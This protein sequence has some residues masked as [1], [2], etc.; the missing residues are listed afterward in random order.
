MLHCARLFFSERTR[1]IPPKGMSRMIRRTCGALRVYAR[2]DLPPAGVWAEDH[3]RFLMDEA[4]ALERDSRRWPRLPEENGAPRLRRAA[5]RIAEAG[6][7]SAPLILLLMREENEKQAWTEAELALMRPAL[8]CALMEEI[9]AALTDLSREAAAYVRAGEQARAFAARPDGALPRDRAERARLIRRMEEME[10]GDALRRADEA[11]R[12]Q[13][14]TAEEISREERERAV[15]AGERLGKRIDALRRLTRLPFDRMAER[16]S[17]AGR[18]L[19]VQDTYRRMD[20][21]SRALYRRAAARIGRRLNTAESAVAR[22]AVALCRD[23]EGHEAEAGYY[24]LERPDLIAEYLMK[25]PASGLRQR[26]RTALFLLPLYGTAALSLAAGILFGAPFF[27]WPLIPLCA[28]EI[29][30]TLYFPLLRRLFPARQLPRIRVKKLTAETRTLVAVPALLTSRRQA[31]RLARHL[32]VLRCANPDDQLHFLLLADFADHDAEEAPQD[33]EIVRAARTAVGELNRRYGGGFYYLHRART[34]NGEQYTGRERKRGALEALNGLLTEGRCADDFAYASADPKA[35]RDRYAF[36]ITLDADTFLPAGAPQ[37]LVGAMLHPLQRGRIGVIQPRM[38]TAP[39]TVRTRTQKLLG[40]RGGTDLYHLA[41]QDLYQDVFGRGSFVGKGIYAPRLWTERLAGRLPVGRLLSHDLI[42]GEIAVSALAEDIVLWDGH[43]SRLA[44][45]EKRLHRWTRGDW[46]LMPFL[47]DRRLPLLSRHK[48]WDNLR[49]SLVPGARAGLMMIGAALGLPALILLGLPWPLHGMGL[50]LLLLPGKA[51]TC[52][53]A[54]ARALYRQLVSHR[55]LLS[56]V[57]AAQGEGSLFPSLIS[58]LSPVVSGGALAF[59]SLSG[60]PFWLGVLLGGAW[61][62]S[63]LLIPWLDGEADRPRPLTNA[64]E[65]G[66]R[67]LARDTWRFFADTVSAR[68]LF[69]PPDNVQTDPEKGPALRTSPTNVGL[70]LLSCCA[71]RELGLISAGEAARRVSDTVRTLEGLETW[72]GHFF[73]WYGL[74]DG[75]PLQPRFVSTVDSGNL[76]GC[77]TACAQL[78]RE[79]MREMTDEERTLP[80]RLDALARRMDFACLYDA[81]ARLFRVGADARTGRLADACYDMLASEARLASYFAVMT[82]QAPRKHWAALGRAVV[83]AGGGPALLS[84]GGTMFEYLMPALLLPLT[85]GTLLG[86]GCR[87][88]MKAQIAFSRPFGISESGYYAFDAEMNY[89]YRAFGVPALALNAET[90]GRAAAPYASLLALPFAPRAVTDNIRRMERLGWR[91]ETGF[92]EAADR[93]EGAA[94]P[95]RIVKS[96]MAHHQGMILCALCNALCGQALVRAFMTPPEAQACADLLWEKA[97]GAARRR[98]PGLPPRREEKPNDSLWRPARSGLPVDTH[99]LSGGGTAWLVSAQ[100]QGYLI[101][102]GMMITRFLEEAGS[103]TGWQT[104]LRDGRTGAV[105]RPAVRGEAEFGPGCVRFQ[106]RWRGWHVRERL[107]VDPLTGMAVRAVR[108]RNEEKT[109]REAEIVS[110]LEIAQ[111]PRPADAAHPNFRDLSVRVSPWGGR[112]LFSRRLPRDPADETPL[113]GHTLLGD[114]ASLCRQGDRQLFLGREGDYALPEQ[115]TGDAE[116]YVLRTGDVTAPCLCLRAG[117]RMAAGEEITLYF[118]VC[119][120]ENEEALERLRLT[121]EGLRNVFSLADTHA[122]MALRRLHMDGRML[123]MY[124]QAL[125]A[126]V[127][128]G[129]PHQCEAPYPREGRSALWRLSASGEGI[130]VTVN[131]AEGPDRALIGH[132]LRWRR[133]LGE[134]GIGCELIFLCPPEE[135]YLTPC[136][137]AAALLTAASGVRE[138]VRIAQASENEARAAESLARLT[139]R[140]GL[141]LSEQLRALR[142][143]TE[144][145]ED[146]RPS[147]P[148]PAAPPELT[149]YNGLGGFTADGSYWIGRPAPVPWH[150]LLCGAAFG[151][152]VCETGILHSWCGNSRLM[153]MT[154]L[155]PDPYRAL[156]AEE[157]FLKDEGGAVWPLARCAALHEMGV[158]LYRNRAGGVEAAVD[159]FSH[160]DR[161]FGV[162]SVTLKSEEERTVALAYLVRFSM[163][164]NGGDTRCRAEAGMA[165]ARGDMRG[166]AWAAMEEG[167]AASLSAAAAFGL[168]GERT[169]RALLRPARGP[170]SAALL[171]RQVTL[172]ARK[173][174]RVTLALGWAEEEE[175]ARADFA[176]LTEAGPAPALREVREAWGRRL[177]ALTLYAGVPALERAVNRWLPYQTWTARLLARMGP[178]QQGGAYGFRDQL[179]DLLPLLYT[180]PAFAR[181]HI[182]L[183]AAHQFPEGDVQHW[184]HPPRRG[185]RTRISDDRIFLPYMT[186]QYVRVTGDESILREQTPYLL[187]PPLSP[188]ERERY[189]EPEE[190]P[191]TEPLLTHCMR[192]LDAAE[193]G[194]HGMPRMGSGDWND[195]MDRVG[196]ESVWLGF[197]LALTLEDFLPL[198]P[199]DVRERYREKRRRLLADAE[200]AWTGMWYLRAW[201]ADGT[202]MGGPE[203][204]PPRIDLISQCFAALAGAPRDHARTALHNALRIL[205]DRKTGIIRLLDPPFAPEE[206]AGYI[207]AYLPGVR[208][209]GGQ[210]T[211]AAAWLIPALCRLGEYETAWEALDCLLPSFR[212]AGADGARVYRAEPY[213]LAADVYAGENP[214]RAGWTWYT[215]SAAWLYHGIVTALLGFEKAGNKAR[216]T[217]RPGPET[218]EYTVAYRFG[219]ARYLFTAARDALFP[220]LDGT[221]LEDGWAVLTADGRAHEARFPLRGG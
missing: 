96:Y 50:R 144:A 201:Y 110:F 206:G 111:G 168:R 52:L 35:L 62:L 60:G 120:A 103:Q 68:T 202:P 41:A 217:P 124:Q 194:P 200:N 211:H 32:A 142:T 212:C 146:R 44:G 145:A 133:W 18:V 135:G 123:H 183:C 7:I 219:N 78:M 72:R 220:T 208:E 138:G 191:W 105:I 28:S 188:E 214:G 165:F 91:G 213:V 33:G 162:R 5:G 4:E 187:S 128:T 77:L 99:V 26:R 107:A 216:L 193:T 74:K 56:W 109:E 197:F 46:Q 116:T 34:R 207:G 104:Y 25:R 67:S 81:G 75:A 221:R 196:G 73:N 71:A 132:A 215:G 106:A 195:G 8:S 147:L 85:P 127:W 181:A 158:T 140:S 159:V 51:R 151:T 141:T 15:R 163:G 119:I 192:A 198:C 100:G 108:L 117:V 203:T 10:D 57:T 89:Q 84:W 102:R 12:R 58:V 155:S 176:A 160:R 101:H 170:G 49:R 175:Q 42:E 184:W 177:D 167:R 172:P 54:A 59:L 13:G 45:W 174:V 82:G 87:N 122:R 205:E 199:A 48:I 114:P 88:A 6:E 21:E 64:M 118:A 30:R 204:E 43:P 178:Y 125:G 36:V 20:A 94:G 113:I 152:L 156:P 80:A 112:G 150:N 93:G 185:V 186:A 126:T 66:L 9:R 38:E 69:L 98:R 134:A 169:P 121:E 3:A 130:T 19:C 180:D 154:R 24:L 27:A 129:Q 90:E 190:T 86:E 189:E 40:G 83:R 55:R 29:A 79:R 137:D 157:I 16:L 63:P 161:P 92:Y 39:D 2:E 37:R 70:Y 218:E 166:L 136:R 22:A 131:L 17:E 210:Y 97:P 95:V 153:K 179:Q 53:D 139:L 61:I 1:L 171:E 148:E 65:A 14:E 164:E 23:R 182:L 173:A 76:A 47:R 11:L 31:L 209:N 149:E 115:L 143:R